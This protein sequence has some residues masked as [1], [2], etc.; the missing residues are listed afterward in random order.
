MA[1]GADLGQLPAGVP[2]VPVD[3]VGNEI[4]VGVVAQGLAVDTGFAAVEAQR[5][6]AGLGVLQGG[7]LTGCVS[8]LINIIYIV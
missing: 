2:A 3:G 4:A 6:A 1:A 7:E 8:L 5:C